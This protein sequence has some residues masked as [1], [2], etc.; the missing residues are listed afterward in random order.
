[1][2]IGEIITRWPRSRT[3]R[4]I[5][6]LEEFK[7]KKLRPE[8]RLSFPQYNELPHNYRPQTSSK[9][10]TSTQSSTQIEIVYSNTGDIITLLVRKPMLDIKA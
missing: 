1:M 10:I 5:P 6:N 3:I 8:P 9:T 2:E 7:E 4:P